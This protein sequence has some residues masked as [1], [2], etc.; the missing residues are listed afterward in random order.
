[1]RKLNVRVAAEIAIFA[2]LGVVL[3]ILQGGIAKIV[4]P[5]L[6]AG[7]SIGIAMVPI[8]VIAYR[9][10]LI[11]GLLCALL[12]SILQ[13]LGGI[14]VINSGSLSGWKSTAGPYIQVLLDYILAYTV[15]GFAG[16]FAGLYK[17]SEGN[18]KLIF[19]V[20]GCVLAGF[21]KY[22]CH[23]LSG[24]FFWPGELWGISGYAYSWVY[25]GIYMIP[26]II[27]C[28]GIMVVVAKFYPQFLE[29]SSEIKEEAL[30]EKK[31]LAEVSE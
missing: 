9:R 20:I 6:K 14:Y 19:I 15:C 28:A 30:E 29:D 21:L 22:L 26:N 8:F 18:K 2:A 3:D 7:G 13:M 24:I 17:N 27:I 25:N 10:G 31:D 11:A 5:V 23:V 12:V 1:M 4:L 16:A